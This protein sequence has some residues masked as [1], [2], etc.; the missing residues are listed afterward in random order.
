MPRST[1]ALRD[2]LHLAHDRIR[3]FHERQRPADSEHTDDTGAR[4]GSRWRA[5][6]AAGVYVPGG[7]AAYP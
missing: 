4:T 2:A 7:R 3:L 5:V 1:P 6:D